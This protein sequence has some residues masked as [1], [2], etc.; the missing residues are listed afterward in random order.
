MGYFKPILKKFLALASLA[1][2]NDPTSVKKFKLLCKSYVF[3]AE[4]N[5]S[6]H[7]FRYYADEKGLGEPQVT[8]YLESI[9]PATHQVHLLLTETL[10]SYQQL[11]S[12]FNKAAQQLEM[13]ETSYD[14]FDPILH[15]LIARI[16]ADLNLTSD[17]LNQ[18][19]QMI[20]LMADLIPSEH[21]LFQRVLASVDTGC[22]LR[23]QMLTDA[24]QEFLT[25]TEVRAA[26]MAAQAQQDVDEKVSLS[27]R[28]AARKK[29]N[30]Q[31]HCLKHAMLGQVFSSPDADVL[32]DSSLTL[33][34]NV[35]QFFQFQGDLVVQAQ[36]TARDL[37]DVSIQVSETLAT[38]FPKAVREL[39]DACDGSLRYLKDVITR[40]VFEENSFYLAD[41]NNSVESLVR[42]YQ[43]FKQ[44]QKVDLVIEQFAKK[45]NLR[46]ALDKYCIFQK[47]KQHVNDPKLTD[48]SK[49]VSCKACYDRNKTALE[50]HRSHIIER[51]FYKIV[52]FFSSGRY[53]QSTAAQIY[54]QRVPRLK[55]VDRFFQERQL[56]RQGASHA[57]ARPATVSR[58]RPTSPRSS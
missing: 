18:I 23:K 53:G 35:S 6:R 41:G 9:L 43:A 55:I 49:L 2:L 34:Q 20:E 27:P 22:L 15:E 39:S 45:E 7:I 56:R 31:H 14:D 5:E 10:A 1:N 12:S 21:Y 33:R 57:D 58:R 36:A 17:D 3:G 25:L 19:N 54:N 46:K 47:M 28:E 16:A 24:K 29:K 51:I 4:L 52:A 40:E 48:F 42:A 50:S 30:L 8:A 37:D 26:M 13:K 11:V 38:E 44:N 32:D